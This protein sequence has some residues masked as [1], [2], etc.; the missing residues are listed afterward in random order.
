MAQSFGA[1]MRQRREERQIALAA[2]V[3]KTK[4][5]Q[6]LL[7]AMERDDL[8][9]WPNGF[10]RRAFMRAYAQ[11]IGLDP[12]DVVREFLDFHGEHVDDTGAISSLAPLD[13]ARANSAPPTRL[14]QMVGSAMTRFRSAGQRPAT[15]SDRGD[16]SSAA[17]KPARGRT[18]DTDHIPL[19]DLLALGHLCAKLGQARRTHNLSPLLQEA[20]RMLDASGLIIWTWDLTCERLRASW[21][22]GYSQAVLEQLPL[23][24]L[25]AENAVAA[26]FR[27]VR[28]SYVAGGESGCVA[29][30]V[31]LVTARGC[32][33]VLAAE[34]EQNG[35]VPGRVEALAT[36]VA[37]QLARIVDEP[38]D[39]SAP[40]AA[41]VNVGDTGS[42]SSA[43]PS[44]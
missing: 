37:A 39:E 23:V 44:T 14:R 12:D 38:P 34:L 29:V 8:S 43:H 41:S 30:V 20:A 24:A 21:A 17:M 42:L 15:A 31:P 4:I 10:F 25:E 16:T 18:T 27:S 33:G 2:I 19:G 26:A 35:D 1:H 13:N 22:H 3:E 32:A 7:E 28:T 9:Q 11:A 5:K 36:I 6:S 40:Q